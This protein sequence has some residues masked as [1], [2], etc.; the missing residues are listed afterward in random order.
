LLAAGTC[1]VVDAIVDV[2]AAAVVEIVVDRNVLAWVTD[3]VVDVETG[4]REED[5]GGDPHC[6]SR[7]DSH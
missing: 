7:A 4:G 1:T 6:Q 5:E 2:A 3:T